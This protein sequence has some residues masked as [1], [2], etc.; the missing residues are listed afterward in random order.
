MFVY[1]VH[2]CVHMGARVS[3]GYHSLEAVPDVA[4]LSYV[5]ICTCIY[6]YVY[7]CT[8]TQSLWGPVLVI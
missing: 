3:L 4:F 8:H 5:Y 7:L 6:M 2:V 1:G